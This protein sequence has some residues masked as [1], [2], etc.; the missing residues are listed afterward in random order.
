MAL[1]P[2]FHSVNLTFV[3]P[4]CG[5]PLVKPGSWFKAAKGFK[6]NSCKSD[7]RLTYTNKLALFDLYRRPIQP[8]GI[9]PE[10]VVARSGPRNK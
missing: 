1:S 10:A 7:I 4:Q 2:S 5:H 9:V 3:C 6:C 8:A